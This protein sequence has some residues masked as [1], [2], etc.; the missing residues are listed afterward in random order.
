VNNKETKWRINQYLAVIVMNEKESGNL[1]RFFL[2]FFVLL[3][4]LVCSWRGQYTC[5]VSFGIFTIISRNWKLGFLQVLQLV[6]FPQSPSLALNSIDH[7]PRRE[8]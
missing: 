2:F 7:Q 6:S 3:L 4:L 8:C 1:Q 5:T